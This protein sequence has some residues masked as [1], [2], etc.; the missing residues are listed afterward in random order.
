LQNIIEVVGYK[1]TARVSDVRTLI[2]YFV[3]ASMNEWEGFH[4]GS[5]V[6]ATY[7]LP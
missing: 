4:H 3:T 6:A 1:Y 5:A 7:V 2:H